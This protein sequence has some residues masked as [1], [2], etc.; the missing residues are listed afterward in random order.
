MQKCTI[1]D[2]LEN[3]LVGGRFYRFAAGSTMLMASSA[4]IPAAKTG[5]A[6]GAG[7]RGPWY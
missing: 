5:K 1:P 7:N 2:D 3:V 4:E 6:M